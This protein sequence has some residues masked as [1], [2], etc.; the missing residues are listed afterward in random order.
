MREQ[1][2][3]K[4][5]LV[6]ASGLARSTILRALDK[7]TH[8]PKLSTMLAIAYVLRVDISEILERYQR[9]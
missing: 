6:R 7:P 3:N 2:L 5:D 4:E 1:G 9:Q 8:D